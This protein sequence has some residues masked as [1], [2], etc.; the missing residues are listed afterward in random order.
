[1]KIIR[2]FSYNYTNMIEPSTDF[3]YDYAFEIIF[4]LLDPRLSDITLY[5]SRYIAIHIGSRDP[6]KKNKK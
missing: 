6:D 3:S 4:A 5:F 2:Y 1:M